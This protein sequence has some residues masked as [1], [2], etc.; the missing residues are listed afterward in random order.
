M[1]RRKRIVWGMSSSG[2]SICSW[3]VLRTHGPEAEALESAGIE[4]T[5]HQFNCQPVSGQSSGF[6]KSSRNVS[7]G[8]IGYVIFLPA[9]G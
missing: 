9:I 7:P 3:G 8:W 4:L 1:G 2:R 5:H 6:R